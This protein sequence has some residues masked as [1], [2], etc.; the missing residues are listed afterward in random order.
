MA[1]RSSAP[2]TLPLSRM[3]SWVIGAASTSQLGL[4]QAL[5]LQK[6]MKL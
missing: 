4:R 5:R 6:C 2:S 3:S 1:D